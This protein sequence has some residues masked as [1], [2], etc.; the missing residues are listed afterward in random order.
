[1]PEK[2]HPNPSDLA[3]RAFWVFLHSPFHNWCAWHEV[4]LK[5]LKVLKTHKSGKVIYSRTELNLQI[6]PKIYILLVLNDRIKNT[7]S[8]TEK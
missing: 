3:I 1:M 5:M 4:G 6:N 7:L 2:N 8:Y